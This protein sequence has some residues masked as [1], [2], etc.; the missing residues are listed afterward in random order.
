MRTASTCNLWVLEGGGS[1][2]EVYV[3]HLGECRGAL[4]NT[5]EFSKSYASYCLKDSLSNGC[6]SK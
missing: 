1:M 5:S 6:V 4:R 2:A 3:G